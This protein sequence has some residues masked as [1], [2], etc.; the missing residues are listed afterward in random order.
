M[1]VARIVQ[2]CG[3]D[4]GRQH[5]DVLAALDLTHDHLLARIA[6]VRGKL[7]AAVEGVQVGLG[8]RLAHLFGVERLG[9]LERILPDIDG[10][11]GLRRLVR[12]DLVV[13]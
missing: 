6:A 11:A 5:Y 9:A 4:L 10:R 12:H 2:R 1:R 13:G 7:D 8:Q 3:G